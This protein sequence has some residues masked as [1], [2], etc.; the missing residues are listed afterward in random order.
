MLCA[1]RG[2]TGAWG[3]FLVLAFFDVHAL[4]GVGADTVTPPGAIE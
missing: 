3:R 2:C 4:L 1:I